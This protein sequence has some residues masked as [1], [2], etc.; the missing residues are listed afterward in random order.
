VTARTR[1]GPDRDTVTGAVFGVA[2]L[3]ITLAAC[4]GYPHAAHHRHPRRPAVTI[5]VWGQ[6]NTP[7]F[8][9]PVITGRWRP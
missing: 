4:L 3:A 5:T 6:W 9:A 7:W 8:S 1:R 2:V